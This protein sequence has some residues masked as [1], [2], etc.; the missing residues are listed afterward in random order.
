MTQQTPQPRDWI[1]VN[2][3]SS[4]ASGMQGSYEVVCLY[5]NN[6]VKVRNSVTSFIIPVSDCVVVKVGE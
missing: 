2:P 6:M 5:E 4:Y 1:M 3:E